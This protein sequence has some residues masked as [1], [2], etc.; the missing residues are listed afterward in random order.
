MLVIVDIGVCNPSRLHST[1]ILFHAVQKYIFVS[2]SY[3]IKVAF[4][5]RVCIDKG[6]NLLHG[7]LEK[8]IRL[9]QP[10]LKHRKVRI[11]S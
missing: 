8:A 1:D 2:D 3:I 6:C 4:Q 5:N 10:F 9:K 7:F 11:S